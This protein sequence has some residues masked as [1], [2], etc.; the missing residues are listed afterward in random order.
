MLNN[1]FHHQPRQMPAKE[2]IPEFTLSDERVAI[3]KDTGV[4]KFLVYL[5]TERQ[6]SENT[7]KSYFLDLAH[8]LHCQQDFTVISGSSDFPWDSITDRQA[9]NFVLKL[10]SAGLSHSSI[11]RKLASLKAFFRFLLRE[12]IISRNPFSLVNCLKNSRPLPIVLTVGQVGK[13]LEAPASY[14]ERQKKACD[15]PDTQAAADFAAVRDKAILEVIYSGGLRISEACGLNFEDMDFLGSNFR[16]RGKGQKERICLLGKPAL[17]ALRSY[18][19]NRE[20]RGL[21]LRREPGALFRNQQNGRLSTRSVER[22]FKLYIQEAGLSADCTPHKLRHSF[23]THLLAAGAD[24]R[25]VQEMLGHASL[26]STQIYTHID[27]G[28]LIE[29]YAK[30]HP[31]A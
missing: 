31:K 6:Y 12:D 23:A 1:N 26:S 29:V 9:R 14:W 21:G 24:L 7:A 3:A 4:T 28:Q 22:S 5:R 8:F 11:N 10:S 27:I 15:S 2:K 13:L 20:A 17:L 30:A 18:L 16:V 25:V 19:Q